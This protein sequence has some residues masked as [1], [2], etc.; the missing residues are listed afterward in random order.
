M[1]KNRLLYEAAEIFLTCT[2]RRREIRHITGSFVT[3][4]YGMI[5]T[6]VGVTTDPVGDVSATESAEQDSVRS[7]ENLLT[8]LGAN[9]AL[10]RY[11]E[12]LDRVMDN[13]S[14]EIE[15]GSVDEASSTSLKMEDI[16][17]D[18]IHAL[19]ELFY[20]LPDPS[21]RGDYYTSLC[22]YRETLGSKTFRFLLL[23]QPNIFT[24]FYRFLQNEERQ[25]SGPFASRSGN[26]MD[27]DKESEQE[28]MSS[29]SQL[30][31]LT[32]SKPQIEQPGITTPLTRRRSNG[33]E[34]LD[35]NPL[36]GTSSTNFN[37]ATS[38]ETEAM[39]MPKSQYQQSSTL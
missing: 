36:T 34:Q 17:E 18:A 37:G 9:L 13:E 12:T 11:H 16:C 31:S 8:I 1:L 24:E 30:H 10:L 23:T 4:T 21:P 7:L 5:M 25:S 35:P 28:Q 20:L 26:Q 14:M 39:E 27:L 19:K 15:R 3:D 6:H 38:Q 2:D 22:D 32:S 29:K 33:V